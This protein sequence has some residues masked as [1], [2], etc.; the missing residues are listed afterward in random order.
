M[1]TAT[2]TVGVAHD[3]AD[4]PPPV[5]RRVGAD[6]V[7]PVRCTALPRSSTDTHAP[8]VGQ[9]TDTGTRRAV[10]AGGW[11]PAR[12][13]TTVTAPAVASTPTATTIPRRTR[14]PAP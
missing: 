5:L 14:R 3:T 8:S 4:M 1:S 9:D 6:H 13:T 2:Q 11:W 10:D 12:R 7:V